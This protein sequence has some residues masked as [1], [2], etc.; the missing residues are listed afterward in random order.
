MAVAVEVIRLS[1][2]LDPDDTTTIDIVRRA[3]G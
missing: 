3:Q 2:T 1:G